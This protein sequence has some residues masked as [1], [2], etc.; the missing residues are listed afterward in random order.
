MR[1]F[2]LAS[3]MAVLTII[4]SVFPVFS[5]DKD[6]CKFIKVNGEVLVTRSGVF[7]ATQATVG[8]ELMEGDVIDARDGKAILKF[9]N[10]NEVT[11]KNQTHFEIKEMKKEGGKTS[12]ALNAW[13]GSLKAN[14]GKLSNG[15]SFKVSTPTA[16]CG[17]RGTEFALIISDGKTDCLVL[18]GEVAFGNLD[19]SLEIKVRENEIGSCNNEG[20]VENPRQ[21]EKDEK[22]KAEKGWQVSR[23]LSDEEKDAKNSAENEAKKDKIVLSGEVLQI[24]EANAL[25]KRADANERVADAQVGKVITDK[26]GYRVKVDQYI[27]RPDP[28]TAQFLDINSRQGEGVPEHLKLNY[29]DW[30]L[31]FNKDL[32]IDYANF[33]FSKVQLWKTEPEYYPLK[34]MIKVA[35]SNKPTPDY[36]KKYFE[37]DLDHKQGQ[38]TDYYRYDYYVLKATTNQFEVNGVSKMT[39]DGYDNPYDVE[40]NYITSDGKGLKLERKYRDGT[41]FKEEYY[42]VD[43]KG[44]AANPVDFTTMKYDKN[45][46]YNLELVYSATEF[47]GRTIDVVVIPGL[48]DLY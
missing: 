38:Y 12:T 11:V 16:V 30:E 26:N 34:E 13:K 28:Q 9:D 42:L 22:D 1:K 5:E 4:L 44:G 6:V 40:T 31:K 14:M 21:M 20:K 15:S 48:I 45:N 33:A 19:G 8:M 25:E 39:A 7:E 46:V 3:G 41:F 18:R 10:G 27:M 43:D 2:W 23:V 32:P 35:N 29:I 24:L 36:W 37:Y 47:N 17:V